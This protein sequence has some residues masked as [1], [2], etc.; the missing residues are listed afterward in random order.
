MW[1]LMWMV[2]LKFVLVGRAPTLVIRSGAR[3]RLVGVDSS[4]ARVTVMVISNEW[5]GTGCSWIGRFAAL[6]KLWV[7]GHLVAF[8][9][10]RSDLCAVLPDSVGLG[11]CCLMVVGGIWL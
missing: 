9:G 3:V 11:P 7:V 5:M 10:G 6:V 4:V 8:D 1:P 2:A